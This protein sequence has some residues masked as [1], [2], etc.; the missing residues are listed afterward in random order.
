MVDENENVHELAISIDNDPYSLKYKDININKTFINL[1]K[2]E[3]IE[4]FR[5]FDYPIIIAENVIITYARQS[6]CVLQDRDELYEWIDKCVVEMENTEETRYFD[7]VTFGNGEWNT[8][9]LEV[10]KQEIDLETNYNDN[11]PHAEIMEFLTG[12]QSGLCI[13]HGN[14]GTGK[15]SYIRYLMYQLVDQSFLVI[16]NSAFNF[17]TDASFIQLLNDYRNAVIILEDCESMLTDRL[18]GNNKLAALL[19]LSDGIIGDA[20]NFKFICTFNANVNKIDPAVLRKGRMKIKYEFEKL[21]KEKTYALAQK[22][23]IN[24][25]KNQSLTLSDIY[26]YNDVTEYT[27]TNKNKIGFNKK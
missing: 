8:I 23:G 17:I 18:G 9:T 12:N 24:I 19:N 5:Y 10:K 20:F 16:D 11:L 22:L 13:L 2:Q 3:N 15:T 4:Y 7:Y 21:S 1:S 14:P 6:V 26:N 25:D 27:D